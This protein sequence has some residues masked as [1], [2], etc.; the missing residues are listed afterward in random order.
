[1]HEGTEGTTR[2][3]FPHPRNHRQRREDPAESTHPRGDDDPAEHQR[4]PSNRDARGR[5]E[6]A[7]KRNNPRDTHRTHT[8][9]HEEEA[10]REEEARAQEEAG[11]VAR[12]AARAGALR[13][14]F[15]EAF[16]R[17]IE[18]LTRTTTAPTIDNVRN[19]AE[20]A[21]A[22]AACVVVETCAN[23]LSLDDEGMKDRPSRKHIVELL[24]VANR[25]AEALFQLVLDESLDRQSVDALLDHHHRRTKHHP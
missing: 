10:G 7:Q 25:T 18:T 11:D 8:E 21:V 15:R 6:H 14:G 24:E 3:G 9:E 23:V 20:L 22:K 19:L 12:R 5:F 16:D 17:E 4:T 13:P 2:G 1:M